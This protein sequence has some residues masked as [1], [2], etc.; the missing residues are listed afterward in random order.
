MSSGQRLRARHRSSQRLGSPLP[1]KEISL[2]LNYIL[3]SQSVTNELS[4]RVHTYRSAGW[5]LVH[6]THRV[7]HSFGSECYSVRVASF[8]IVVL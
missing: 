3:N 2:F 7:Y 8:Y 1:Y 6:R 5:Q 4:T